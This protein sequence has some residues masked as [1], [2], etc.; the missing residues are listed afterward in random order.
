MKYFI[1][2]D[3]H[4]DDLGNRLWTISFG[5]PQYG[6]DSE[7]IC[8]ALSEKSAQGICSLLNENLNK[9]KQLGYG[10]MMK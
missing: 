1:E 10:N 8:W 4:Y 9:S 2:R 5:E 3:K 7:T 6:D